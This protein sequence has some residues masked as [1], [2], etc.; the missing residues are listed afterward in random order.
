MLKTS[1]SLGNA[2]NSGPASNATLLEA[3]FAFTSITSIG[4][5]SVYHR[6]QIRNRFVSF[7]YNVVLT[8]S[9]F[10]LS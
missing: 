8:K 9:S 2:K 6:D 3:I 1:V 5:L 10:V 7:V 4:I